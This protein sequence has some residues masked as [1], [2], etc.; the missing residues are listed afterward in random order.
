MVAQ[1]AFHEFLGRVWGGACALHPAN[2]PPA[3]SRAFVWE[4]GPLNC[5]TG[6]LVFRVLFFFVVP[7][8]PRSEPGP[9]WDTFATPAVAQ[10][11]VAS[12]LLF[13]GGIISSSS[14]R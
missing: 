14:T 8:P 1:D 2:T 4:I 7:I 5:G 6:L 3:Q 9:I 13:F 10:D 12:R 11:C